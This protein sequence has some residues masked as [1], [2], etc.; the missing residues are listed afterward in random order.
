[1][2]ARP[3]AAAQNVVHETVAVAKPIVFNRQTELDA[4]ITYITS[5]DY[6]VVQHPAPGQT[7]QFFVD[8]VTV[9]TAVTDAD[10]VAR[11]AYTF[12]GFMSTHTVRAYSKTNIVY[13]TMNAALGT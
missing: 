13:D 10:G 11:T 6:P 5:T 2:T 9:G 7:V 4:R 8:D 12:T 1:M 3:S